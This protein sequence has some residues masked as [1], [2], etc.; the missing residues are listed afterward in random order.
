VFRRR[1][2]DVQPSP[3]GSATGIRWTGLAGL[4]RRQFCSKLIRSPLCRRCD[5]DARQRWISWRRHHWWNGEYVTAFV[6]QELEHPMTGQARNIVCP[7]CDAINRIPADKPAGRAKCGRCHKPLFTGKPF[8][9]SAKSFAVQIERNDIPVVVDFW[10]DWCGPCKA[11]APAFERVAAELEPEVRFLKVD[12]E[13]EQD[14]AARYNI[15][16]IPML[17]LFR[18]GGIAAQRAGASDAQSLRVWIEQN[19]A[20]SRESAA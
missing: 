17:I 10:A 16:S 9:V 5:I 20:R 15:R 8:P 2:P 19:M 1:N 7:H 18:K 6:I 11:M 12:T 13:T 3:R 14:L 4:D